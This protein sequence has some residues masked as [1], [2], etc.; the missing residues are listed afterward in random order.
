M[1]KSKHPPSKSYHQ[2]FEEYLIKN[3]FKYTSQRRIIVSELFENVKDHIE[4]DT[5]IDSLHRKGHRISR[6]TIY[7]TIK[8][9]LQAQ[10]IRKI[11]MPTNN[12]HYE[13]IYG[14]AHHDH[15]ICT[16]CGK[17]FEFND[18]LIEQRQEKIARE[19]RLQI[20]SHSHILH[21]TCLRKNCSELQNKS[22]L[23][24]QTSG[25]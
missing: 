11:K 10:L 24:R 15:L 2:V 9:L 22:L 20:I 5:F 13:T 14:H 3:N 23:K 12:V 7:S 4:A 8:L 21:G 18:A 6:G 17:I 19:Y 1:R 25:Q 16:D